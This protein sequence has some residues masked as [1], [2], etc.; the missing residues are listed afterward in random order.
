MSKGQDSGII[1]LYRGEEMP[2]TAKGGIAFSPH[3][4]VAEWYAGKKGKVLE[5]KLTREEFD[6]LPF[7]DVPVTKGVKRVIYYVPQD[8]YRRAKTVEEQT[9]VPQEMKLL[10]NAKQNLYWWTVVDLRDE[11]IRRGIPLPKRYSK[12]ELIDLL[13][14]GLGTHPPFARKIGQVWDPE[15][16]EWVDV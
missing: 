6:K 2:T 8:I 10:P 16:H 14:P 13:V 11:C 3:R 5:L 12:K 4:E 1:T 7:L 9:T 15:K